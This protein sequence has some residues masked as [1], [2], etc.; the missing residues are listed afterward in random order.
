MARART[1]NRA[2]FR[3]YTVTRQYNLYG[4]DLDKTK[5]QITADVV[6]VPP[7]SK[8]Y[9]IQQASGSGL[10]K[11]IVRRALANEAE[12]AKNYAATD[13]S[14]ENYAFRF[15]RRD[16]LNGQPCYVLELLPRRK[17]V[18]L[19]HGNLWLDAGTYLPRRVEGEL[20]KSPSWWVRDLQV[21]FVYG[22]I[23]GMWLPTSSEASA[24][25]RIL[26]RSTMVSRDVSYKLNDVVRPVS[27]SVGADP[28]LAQLVRT[29]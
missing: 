22:E 4:K 29:P 11:M 5:S 24:T 19:V 13:F 1:Q 10:G 14:P 21:K 16:E 2:Q 8:K 3:P 17:D 23:G 12:M 6:F 27:A 20:A 15:L 9:A 18:H 26:G 28:H 25:L 7:D